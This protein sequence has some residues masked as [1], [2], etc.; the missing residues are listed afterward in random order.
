MNQNAKN[1]YL[2]YLTDIMDRIYDENPSLYDVLEE[3]ILS[4]NK[5]KISFLDLK[6]KA[7]AV[8]YE[9]K[10]IKT[11]TSQKKRVLFCIDTLNGGGAEK[12]LIDI[13]SRIDVNKF[14]I[15]LL[16]LNAYG[17]YF[18]EIPSY[19]NWHIGSYLIHSNKYDIEIAFL[20]GTPTKYIAQRNSTAIKIAWVHTDL[21][22]MHW[23]KIFYLGDEEK[24]CYLSM[25]KIVFVSNAV[26]SQFE[27]MFP[28][29]TEHSKHVIHNLIDK[30]EI[31]EKAKLEKIE[32]EKLTICSIGRLVNQ[33]GYERLIPIIARLV[34]EG[35]D[36]H[37]WI[38]GTGEKSSSITSL[39]NSYQL[40]N[41]VIMKGY[42][43]NPYPYIN[44]SDIYIS[45][46]Y[47]EGYSLATCE[48]MCLSKPI[49]ATDTAGTNEILYNGMYGHIMEQNEESIYN[50]LKR[51]IEDKEFRIK[52]AQKSEE[53][54]L[55]F[56]PESKMN[57][58][59]SLLN[60]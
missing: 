1:I 28:E 41:T 51:I 39:I 16:I 45:V 12:L 31:R 52:L 56:S 7:Y 10:S 9:H 22:K 35:L 5:G 37:L 42:C 6:Q 19:I 2:T 26:K 58:I 34:A 60:K 30:D 57:Q 27:I 33:K 59:H 20:E 3:T 23:T 24:Q 54:S 18:E 44:A 43:P 14:E 17:V 50:A 36:F 32:T 47:A 40:Q 48:A 49:L 29:I 13:L 15:D 8:Y 53:G 46:S 38:I 25:D 4:F 11:P 21:R 55:L